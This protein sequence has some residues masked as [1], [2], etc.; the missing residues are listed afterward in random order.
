MSI[1][2]CERTLTNSVVCRRMSKN[3]NRR[4]ITRA[5]GIQKKARIQITHRRGCFSEDEASA[6]QEGTRAPVGCAL[7]NTRDASQMLQLSWSP[8]KPKEVWLDLFCRLNRG[9]TTKLHMRVDERTTANGRY[10][11]ESRFP[12]REIFRSLCRLPS[13]L[14]MGPVDETSGTTKRR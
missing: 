2:L 14:G 9:R 5:G 10:P 6:V 12:S 11:P 8:N 3:T 1:I 4:R 13:F 7:A